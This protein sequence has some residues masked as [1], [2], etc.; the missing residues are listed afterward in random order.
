MRSINN[1]IR[2][3]WFSLTLTAVKIKENF[4]SGIL[5]LFI[6]VFKFKAMVCLDVP[7][8]VKK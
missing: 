7:K 4:K 5:I 6:N 8:S 3:F 1:F 2:N